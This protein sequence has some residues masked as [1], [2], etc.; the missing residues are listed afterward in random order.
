MEELNNR[1][2]AVMSELKMVRF[3][4]MSCKSLMLCH[5]QKCE[6]L[7]KE[8]FASRELQSKTAE[9]VNALRNQIRS[10]KLQAKLN[11]AYKDRVRVLSEEVQ[12][13][14]GLCLFD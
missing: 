7:Q 2:Q 4:D 5:A 9:D 3:D 10:F 8:N 12:D 1:A 13:C 6:L 11:A 14:C